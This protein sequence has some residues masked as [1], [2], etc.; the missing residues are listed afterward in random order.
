MALMAHI[1]KALV[2]FYTNSIRIYI[3]VCIY[4]TYLSNI[5]ELIGQTP[6][7]KLNNGF[8]KKE[9]LRLYVKLEAFNPGSS[10][11]D[12][13][14]LS[15]IGPLNAM[16]LSSPAIP[17]LKQPAEILV[18]AFHGVGAAKK[19]YKVVI[20]MPSHMSVERRKITQ[21]YGAEL[22]LTP[23]SEGMKAGAIAKAQRNRTR[24]KCFGC[25]CS[26]TTR[27]IQ[28]FTNEQQGR[29]HRCFR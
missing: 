21:A 17:S 1:Y 14:A 28:G 20:V 22:V 29:N 11:K 8:Q 3:E 6:I 2:S 12:R 16:A 15:M 19:G 7:V 10:V 18:L 25:R 23:G 27:P 26:L 5:T 24:A 9:L 13:I 4:V